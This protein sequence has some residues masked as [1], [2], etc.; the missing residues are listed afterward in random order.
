MKMF[1]YNIG[2]IDGKSSISSIDALISDEENRYDYVLANL[3]FGKKSSCL[4]PI[5]RGVS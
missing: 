4:L 5:N 2:K 3:S 1:L